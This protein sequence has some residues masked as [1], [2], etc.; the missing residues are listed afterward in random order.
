MGLLQE[1]VNLQEIYISPPYD[2]DFWFEQPDPEVLIQ[3]ETSKLHLPNGKNGI[4]LDI[5]IETAPAYGIEGRFNEDCPMVIPMGE[6]R[7]FVAVHDGASSRKPIEGLIPFGVKG[8]Y[9]VSHLASLH[10]PDSTECQEL[11]HDPDIT[12]G[13]VMRK[14]NRWLKKELSK[15]PG[16]DYNDVLSVPGMSATYALI[17]ARKNLITIAHVADTV[18]CIETPD[19]NIQI[20]TK[21]QNCMYDDE[22][23]ALVEQI[24]RDNNCNPCDVV[25]DKGADI[26]APVKKQLAESFEKKINTPDGCGILN[27]QPELEINN[28]IYEKEIQITP[29]SILVIASDGETDPYQG[30]GLCEEDVIR[31]FMQDVRRCN[32]GSDLEMTSRNSQIL[33]EDPQLILHPRLRNDDRTIIQVRIS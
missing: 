11:S 12:A 24:A 33:S 10:F 1:T 13:D 6:G 14:V 26:Y 17:D 30:R 4:N 20:L 15:V 7:L 18:A 32:I 8:A 16:V 27:G 21:D 3:S 25:K 23:I 19:G 29:Y 9:Y 31:S 28:L 22:T 5:G 2:R